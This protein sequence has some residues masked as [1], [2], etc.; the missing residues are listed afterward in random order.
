MWRGG[1][2]LD[3]DSDEHPDEHPDA[4]SDGDQ[5]A[6]QYPDTH[7]DFHAYSNGDTHT[8]DCA[9]LYGRAVY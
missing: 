9:C 6:D 3:T 7:G 1:R 4:N 8:H 5:H 2:H